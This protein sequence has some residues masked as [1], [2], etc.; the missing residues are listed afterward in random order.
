MESDPVMYLPD[1]ATMNA[2]SARHGARPGPKRAP[3]VQAAP[4]RAPQPRAGG[5]TLGRKK[6]VAH[7]QKKCTWYIFVLPGML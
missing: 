6:K 3:C 1:R 2:E 4:L 7:V 5:Q